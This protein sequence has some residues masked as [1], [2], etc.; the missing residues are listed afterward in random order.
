MFSI[1]FIFEVFL[2]SWSMFKFVGLKTVFLSFSTQ[3]YAESSGNYLKN[4]ALDQNVRNSTKS[5]TSV[6][7][8][9]TFDWINQENTKENL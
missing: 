2:I 9:P 4:L 7:S 3:N 5:R 6:M 8:G 1:F